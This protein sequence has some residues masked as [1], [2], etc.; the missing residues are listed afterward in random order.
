MLSDLKYKEM[1][2]TLKALAHPTRLF[3]MDKLHEKEHCVCELQELIGVDM[4]TV[5]RHLGVLKNAGIIDS[6][7]VQNQVIY[8]LLCPC[9]LDIYDCVCEVHNKENNRIRQ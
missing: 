8:S 7:K 9:I 2:N 5:S 6:R 1:A 4:S 3:I